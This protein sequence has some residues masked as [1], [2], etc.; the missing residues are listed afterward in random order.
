VL[1][2]GGLRVSE[3]LVLE[4]ENVNRKY[5]T[6][7][8]LHGKGDRARTVGLD[9]GAFAL[10]ERCLEKP[11]ALGIKRCASVFCTLDGRPVDSFYVRHAVKLMKVLGSVVGD[12]TDVPEPGSL[13]QLATGTALLR[14]LAR[15]RRSRTRVT[16]N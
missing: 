11:F 4:A 7:R 12:H 8:N 16:S 9:A 3:T 15:R 1:Y 5:G 2:R 14:L 6:A 10:I 13:L